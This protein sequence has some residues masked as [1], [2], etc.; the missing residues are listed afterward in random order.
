VAV[1][2]SENS[3]DVRLEI[4]KHFILFTVASTLLY[5]SMEFGIKVVVRLFAARL[6]DGYE[7]KPELYNLVSAFRFNSS[8]I[9][10]IS[11]LDNAGV[12]GSAF[13]DPVMLVGERLRAAISSDSLLAVIGHELGHFWHH[14]LLLGYAGLELWLLALVVSTYLLRHCH[15]LYQTFGY[16]H[17]NHSSGKQPWLLTRFAIVYFCVRATLIGELIKP[18]CNMIN[19]QMEYQA[20]AFGAQHA[21]APA[22]CRALVKFILMQFGH[23]PLAMDPVF[24]VYFSGHPS[25]AERVDALKC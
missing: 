11:W 24:A 8:E 25:V 14:H 21:S 9:Y 15:P 12:T 3:L 5:L 4:K 17:P 18:F 7:I 16:T 23:S 19:R 10:S 1:A 6:S 13:G 2:K 20:D 22:L